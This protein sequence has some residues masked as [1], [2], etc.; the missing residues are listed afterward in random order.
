MNN[1]GKKS[2]KPAS[3][4]QAMDAFMEQK[5]QESLMGQKKVKKSAMDAA[6][7]GRLANC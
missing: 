2:K 5:R 7:A 4:K 3:P 1:E 6:Y